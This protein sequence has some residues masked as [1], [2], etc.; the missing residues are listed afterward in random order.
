[1]AHAHQMKVWAQLIFPSKLRGKTRKRCSETLAN[2]DHQWGGGVSYMTSRF[3][4]LRQ[5]IVEIHPISTTCVLLSQCRAAKKPCHDVPAP[6]ICTLPQ[7]KDGSHREPLNSR[8]S[9]PI[10]LPL[11]K[12]PARNEVQTFSNL[13]LGGPRCQ[14]ISGLN[15]VSGLL[16]LL[17]ACR[18]F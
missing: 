12:V 13:T 2:K 18:S 17:E 8:R 14:Q 5:T 16:I 9:T 15:S 4:E 11:A 6:R 1:M 7:L 3:P 10:F